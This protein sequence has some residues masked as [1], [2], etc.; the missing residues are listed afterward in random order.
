MATAPVS[1]MPGGGPAVVVVPSP[2]Q[3]LV[4]ASIHK[5]AIFCGISPLGSHLDD[6]VKEMI[7]CNKYID[8]WSLLSVDQ[9]TVDRECRVYSEKAT[10]R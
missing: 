3:P 6:E 2:A 1:E 4:R 9:S 10:E 8:I 7:W 5:D